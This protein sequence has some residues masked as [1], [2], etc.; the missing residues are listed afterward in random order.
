MAR[1]RWKESLSVAGA[2]HHSSMPDERLV[3]IWR[4]AGVHLDRA[5]ASLTYPADEALGLVVEFQDHNEL[6]LALDQL[7]DVSDAQR[8]PRP[9]WEQLSAAAT[10]MEITQDDP[11]HGAT[12]RNICKHLRQ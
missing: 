8:A 5:R 9:V 11:V 7:S 10:V 1:A 3:E 12:V 2:V 4:R 6:G